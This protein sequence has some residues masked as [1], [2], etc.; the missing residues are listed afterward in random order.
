VPDVSPRLRYI[1]GMAARKKSWLGIVLLFAAGFGAWQVWERFFSDEAG[2]RNLV[3]Q[4]WLE[5][6]PKDQRDLVWA[7]VLV[8]QQ[9]RRVGVLAH[10]SRWRSSSEGFVW[11][12]EKEQLRTRFP[13]DNKGY[14]LRVRTWECA[15]EAPAPFQLCLEAKRGDQTLRF[16]SR[17]DWVVRPHDDGP[18]A[19]D[20]AWLAPA[21]QSATAATE[22]EEVGDGP[23]AAGPSPFEHAN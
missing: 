1:P 16:Y 5:R 11:R 23:E 2:V 18:P 6:M 14:S 17:K 7:A 8:Q 15:G 3:N 22:V 20:I 13:Q 12:L 19:E 4:V 10:A 9:G 21:W